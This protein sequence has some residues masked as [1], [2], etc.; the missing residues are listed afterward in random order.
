MHSLGKGMLEADTD[1]YRKRKSITLTYVNKTQAE[2]A[3]THKQM[4]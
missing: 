2:E 1:R 3:Q 4:N